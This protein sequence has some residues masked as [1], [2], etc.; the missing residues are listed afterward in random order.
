MEN[1]T[2]T[3]NFFLIKFENGGVGLQL[4]H[5][6]GRNILME[7]NPSDNSR[8]IA[9]SLQENI[10][11]PPHGIIGDFNQFWNLIIKTEKESGK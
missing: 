5:E 8:P 7:I 4:T 9:L 10:N 2:Y 6:D 11:T 1:K 3:I